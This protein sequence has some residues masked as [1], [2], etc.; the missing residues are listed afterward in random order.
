MKDLA[1]TDRLAQDAAV[2]FGMWNKGTDE[3]QEVWGTV[4][5]N[6]DDGFKGWHKPLAADLGTCSFR[7]TEQETQT[8]T[9][10]F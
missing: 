5:K 7:V 1:A 8:R 6:R 10:R 9:T 2:I 3:N 4:M